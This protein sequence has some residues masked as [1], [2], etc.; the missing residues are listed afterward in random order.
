M[1]D[2]IRTLLLMAI[3][4]F[5]FSCYYLFEG[6]RKGSKGVVYVG[7][8]SEFDETTKAYDVKAGNRACLVFVTKA[9]SQPPRYFFDC[10]MKR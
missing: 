10:P 9:D 1:K 4:L 6:A 5:T 2:S 7:Q 3:I 8:F